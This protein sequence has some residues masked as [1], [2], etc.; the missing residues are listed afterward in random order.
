MNS[1][2]LAWLERYLSHLAQ[3]RRVSGLTVRHYRRDLIAFRDFCVTQAI[4]NWEAVTGQH[5]RSFVAEQHRCGLSGRSLQRRLSAIRG[6]FQYLL[7]EGC[8]AHNPAHTVRAPKSPRRL[9]ST[10]D[11]DQVAQLLEQTPQGILEVRDHALLELAYSSGLRLTELISLRLADLDLIDASVRVRGKGN[12]TRLLP[13]GR[14]AL[15]ALKC[16]LEQRSALAKLEE[17]AVFVS[18]LGYALTPRAV[19]L[20][21]ARW[22][23]RHGAEGHLHPH[24]LRHSFA[25]HLL[26]SSGDLRAVQELLGHAD[27]RT[28]QIYTHL[29]FQ[30]L[31]EVYDATHPRARK[32]R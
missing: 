32:R 31:A 14:K 29:D 18:R 4:A 24:L 20:R 12:K 30:H 16:W 3:E 17:T 22:A 26:E 13:I 15:D 19:Q 21:F 8:V 7:R 10:F 6:F 11:S 1:A 9:P 2:Q 23:L 27:L 25:S 28:T 5:L